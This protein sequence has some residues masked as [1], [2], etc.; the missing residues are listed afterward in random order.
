[1]Y[2]RR[3]VPAAA[4]RR[5]P[6]RAGSRAAASS[7]PPVPERLEEI[8]RQISWARTFGL[9]LEEISPRRGGGAVPAGRPRR[10][11][12]RGLPA[13]RTGTSTRRS[14]ATRWRA[15]AR[16]G[17]VRI[18][19]A[20]TGARHRTR[21]TTAGS[22]G[23]R[24]DRGDIECEVVVN[25]G[26]M[27][28]AEIARHGRRAGADRPDVAPVPG[29]RGV[30]A[31][32][33]GRRNTPLPTLRDPDLL[34]YFR[35]EVDGLVMGGY[36]RDPAPW[37]ASATPLR[38][39][40]GRLQRP[41]ARRGLGP[42]RGDRRELAACGCRRWPTS[43]IRKLINGPEAFTPDN[44]FCLGETEVAGFFVAAGF[45]AHG[46]AGA[47]GIGKV[48]AE[49]IVDGEP[50]MDVW[51]MDIRRFGRAVPL[52]RRSR[53]PARSR[54]TR[55]TTTSPYPARSA[56]PGGRCASRRCTPWHAAHGAVF[57]EKAGWERVELL[58][59][60]TPSA[61]ATSA[62]GRTAGP[63]RY[64]SPGDR[65]RAP[66]RPATRAGLFDETS[67]AKI[68]V[69]RAG[70]RALCSSGSATTRSRAASATSPT[71][72]RSTAAAASR[73]TSRSRA[74]PRTRSSIVTGTAFGSHDLAWLR[75]QARAPRRATCGSTTSPA[76]Y[77]CFALWGPRA[78]DDPG[79]PHA[80]RPVQRR[81]SRS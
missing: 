47:G 32:R 45:C 66:R 44:E 76:Q 25:C 50:S 60:R 31:G 65:R 52:A 71:P 9:P 80:G 36:E 13:R 16:A 61:R 35:Q 74:W 41:A 37:T 78:R 43:A 70:R 68:E 46:I 72:R 7:S 77:V 58:R 69:Q 33:R 57:G 3:A 39:D 19:H 1:M 30:P 4:G 26:G 62:C 54:T 63:G 11:G 64:W 28:A 22:R 10:R 2:S 27:F 12:R 6:G 23:V 56:R 40:P 51:H 38:R 42:V 55:P 8:R 67:F 81:R 14:C 21:R 29:D 59:R 48:M 20:H 17:G 53:S 15:G 73:R 34:V 18:L 24:T 75:K 79:R 49:W 5:A